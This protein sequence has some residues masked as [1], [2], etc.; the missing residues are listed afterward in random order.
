[1]GYN[2]SSSF[3]PP[4]ESWVPSWNYV[5]ERATSRDPIE[6]ELPE[7]MT[8]PQKPRKVITERRK[9]NLSSRISASS[10]VTKSTAKRG[11]KKQSASAK[12]RQKLVRPSS[13]R[14]LHGSISDAAPSKEEKS[15]KP[16][17]AALR[18][19]L[20]ARDLLAEMR[21][22]SS[23]R[24]NPAPRALTAL[25]RSDS[26][27]LKSSIASIERIGSNLSSS[28]VPS[29]PVSVRRKTMKGQ[30]LRL[31]SYESL[32]SLIPTVTNVQLE[33]YRITTLQVAKIQMTKKT[34]YIVFVKPKEK[35]K[36]KIETSKSSKQ[37]ESIRTSNRSDEINPTIDSQEKPFNPQSGEASPIIDNDPRESDPFNPLSHSITPS[38][39]IVPILHSPRSH[40]AKTNPSNELNH[41]FHS[42]KSYSP[43]KYHSS[44]YEVD[45]S[46]SNRDPQGVLKHEEISPFLN[47]EPKKMNPGKF[48]IR[49]ALRRSS[50]ATP[51]SKKALKSLRDVSGHESDDGNSDAETTVEKNGLVEAIRFRKQIIK[52]C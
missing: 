44:R 22:A 5:K 42:E 51:G 33:Q 12:L 6:I 32:T 10:S 13:Q 19:R 16:T 3:L 21:E 1:M 35:I 23:V 43:M 26:Q 15:D 7:P 49:S 11:S 28:E 38:L 45:K 47:D 17:I 18:S 31:A 50:V 30:L 2:Y 29:T 40:R 52:A 8:C 9:K 20:S 24:K 25:A 37:D 39:E 27:Q 14:H 41:S 4:I 34:C 46:T 48:L 36:V